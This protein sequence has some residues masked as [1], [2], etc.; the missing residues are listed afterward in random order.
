MVAPTAVRGWEKSVICFYETLPAVS[1]INTAPMATMLRSGLCRLATSN[2]AM[3]CDCS[4]RSFTLAHDT[5]LA[6]CCRLDRERMLH[7]NFHVPHF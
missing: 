2:S 7:K 4:G 5:P 1:P 6:T 3:T